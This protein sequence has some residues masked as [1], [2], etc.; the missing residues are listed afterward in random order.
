MCKE[1]KYP[2]P[3]LNIPCTNWWKLW[4]IWHRVTFPPLGSIFIYM[5]ICGIYSVEISLTQYIPNYDHL[6]LDSLVFNINLLIAV[7][8]P[9]AVHYNVIV[10]I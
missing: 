6:E 10:Y 3:I 4:V 1:R 2:G 8:Y 9:A 7:Y 5:N